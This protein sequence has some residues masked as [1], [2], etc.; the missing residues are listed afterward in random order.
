MPELGSDTRGASTNKNAIKR[1]FSA[2]TKIFCPAR[3][4]R[5]KLQMF[6]RPP[7][8]VA[9]SSQSLSAVRTAKENFSEPSLSTMPN[10][11]FA[12]KPLE[13]LPTPWY[14]YLKKCLLD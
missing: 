8:T 13:A 4:K 11:E 10:S 5:A 9:D 3:T 2:I 12:G 1:S 14:K 7:K 6:R